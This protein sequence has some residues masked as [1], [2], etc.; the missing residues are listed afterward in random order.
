MSFP[1]T[2]KAYKSLFN[3]ASSDIIAKL[4]IWASLN[5]RETGGQ[6]FNVA[7][8]AAPASMEQRWP[9]ICTYFGLEGVGPEDSKEVLK[10]SEYLK[11]HKAFLHARGI[12][13]DL[14]SQGEFLD[15]YGYYLDFD[16]QLSLEKARK[17][18]F[19]KEQSPLEGWY[20]SFDQLKEAD[21]IPV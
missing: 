5:P 20:K 15:S 8:Q 1:G 11:K 3:E 18:G 12:K 13:P 7:D 19:M 2:Q 10:P 9:E 14:V 17:A 6:L 21:L 16:R 4:S